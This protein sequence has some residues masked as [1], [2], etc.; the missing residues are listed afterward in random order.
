[1]I[2][3]V[4]VPVTKADEKYI[5]ARNRLI[6]KAEKYAN[7]IN[8]AEAPEDKGIEAWKNAWSYTFLAKMDE[9]W[10][11]KIAKAHK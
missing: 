9:L 7:K 4:T 5:A 8:G 6:P 2:N 10:K 3:S 11:A 1:M